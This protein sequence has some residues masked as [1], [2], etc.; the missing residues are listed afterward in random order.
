MLLGFSMQAVAGCIDDSGAGHT[1]NSYGVITL[2]SGTMCIEGWTKQN[3][4][5]DFYKLTLQSDGKLT[6]TSHAYDHNHKL[7]IGSSKDGG[8]YYNVGG[9]KKHMTKFDVSEG[10]TI[11]II[12]ASSNGT[13]YRLDIAFDADTTGTGSSGKTLTLTGTLR[14]FNQDHPDFERH[15]SWENGYYVSKNGFLNI[16]NFNDGLKDGLEKGNVLDTLGADGKPVV[17]PDSTNNFKPIRLQDWFHDVEGVNMSMPYSIELTEIGDGIYQFSSDA[18]FPADGKLLGNEVYHGRSDSEYNHNFHMTYELHTKF[19]YREG[20]N[21]VFNFVGDDDVWVF[22][23]NKLV[24]DLGGL[25]NPQTESVNLDDIKNDLNLIDGHT[26][27]LD[28]FWAERHTTGSNFT[29]TTSIA[30]EERKPIQV[31]VVEDFASN[32]YQQKNKIKI[33]DSFTLD[34]VLLNNNNEPTNYHPSQSSNPIPMSVLFYTKKVGS[35][36]DVKRLDGVVARFQGGKEYATS[37]EISPD[38]IDSGEY[39]VNV[40]YLNFYDTSKVNLQQCSQSSLNSTL[41]GLP[42]CVNGEKN[43]RAMFGDAAAEKC[44]SKGN[45]GSQADLPCSSGH[46]SNDV[47]EPYNHEYGCYE[48]T[49]DALWDNKYWQSTATL[50]KEENTKPF[51]CSQDAYLFSG[52]AHSRS[53]HTIDLG[54]GDYKLEKDGIDSQINATGYN[55]KDNMIWGYDINTYKVIKIDADYNIV[56]YKVEGLPDGKYYAGDVSLDG[57]LYLKKHNDNTLYRV[58]LNS[59]TPVYKDKITLSR[60]FLSAIT[61]QTWNFGDFAFNPVDGKLYSINEI[62]EGGSHR[63]YRIDP[64][65]GKMKSFDIGMDEDYERF[66]T[67]VF[68]KSGNLYFYASKGKIY[69]IAIGDGSKNSYSYTLFTQT[70][71]KSGGGDGARCPNAEVTSGPATIVSV[72]DVNQSEGDSGTS[73]MTFTVNFD[74]PVPAST[75]EQE[76][77]FWVTATD[78]VN[79]VEPIGLAGVAEE[80]HEGDERDF[81]FSAFNIM[82]V[83]DP[84]QYRS[85][86]EVHYLKAGKTSYDINVSIIGDLYVEPDEEFYLDLYDFHTVQVGSA[87][88]KIDV[89]GDVGVRAIGTIIDD[90]IAMECSSDSILFKENPSNVYNLNLFNGEITQEA[91]NPFST[92]I[93][94]IGFNSKDGAYWGYATRNLM[95]TSVRDLMKVVKKDG[96]WYSQRIHIDKLPADEYNVGD[97][98]DDGK[99]FLKNAQKKEVYVVDVTELSETFLK[100][101]D[102]F[103]LKPYNVPFVDW[104][105][106][107]N[108]HKL[109]A[110]NT[111]KRG[112]SNR[113]YRIDPKNGYVEDLGEIGLNSSS[114][115]A[116]GA[117]FFDKNGYFYIAENFSGKIYRIDISDP[118]H[119][120]PKALF[121]TKSTPTS[122]S[123]GARCRYAYISKKPIV[124]F[125]KRVVAQ[126]GDEGIT[127]INFTISG[128][129]PID[130]SSINL[131]YKI[132]KG[133]AGEKDYVTAPQK[134]KVIKASDQTRE[135]I[136][137][138]PIIKGDKITEK[139]ENFFI[140]FSS[141]DLLI[142]NGQNRIE[143]QIV[144]NDYNIF[145]AWDF[146]SSSKKIKTK[147]VAQPFDLHIV[148]I[149]KLGTV[150]NT[151][152]ETET[153][154][155]LVDEQKC[156]IVPFDGNMDGFV[157]FNYT[158]L[159][160]G[161]FRFTSPSAVKKAKVQ[162]YWKNGEQVYTSC[163]SDTFAIRPEKY[164]IEVP[165]IVAGK[166]FNITLKALD[167]NG[168]VVTNYEEDEDVYDINVTEL[169]QGC[170]L[171]N[172]LTIQKQQFKQGVAV[173]QGSYPDI[174]KLKF[175]IKESRNGNKEYAHIDTADS[176]EDRFISSAEIIS[177]TIKPAAIEMTW[178][179]QNGDELNAYTYYNNIDDPGSVEAMSAKLDFQI[180][181]LDFHNQPLQNYTHTCQFAEDVDVKIVYDLESDE[182]RTPL[183]PIGIYSDENN[184][185][186]YDAEDVGQLSFVKGG[187]RVMHYKVDKRFFDAGQANKL[188]LFNFKRDS[189]KPM[190]PTLLK[191]KEVNASLG[192][193]SVHNNEP[194]EVL[195]LYARAHIPDQTFVGDEGNAKVFYEI[196]CKD[197]NRTKYGLETLRESV[198]SINWYI[199]ENLSETYSNFSVPPSLNGLNTSGE[200]IFA[201]HSVF[202]G[203]PSRVSNRALGIKVKKSPTVVRLKYQPKPYLIFN[204]FNPN[205]DSHSFTASFAPKEKS[206]GGKGNVGTTVDMQIAPRNNLDIIDW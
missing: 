37:N 74:K 46:G 189:S 199:L 89:D 72:T 125:Q 36:E 69:K 136:L 130:F 91:T 96:R 35:D 58:D 11:Y 57:I 38:L 43:Y 127:D 117:V 62:E 24:I 6:V 147:I 5:R 16:Y 20:A 59:G 157:D 159:V 41:K 68:D 206:W 50:I 172:G 187:S 54:T 101:V 39:E 95:D 166:D 76:V 179:L 64:E 152:N 169:G 185:T 55:V 47:A 21:Q 203:V 61:G 9:K 83:D 134:F 44:F 113:L 107:P 184:H 161:R 66:H 90:D 98:D 148:K 78:G 201:G 186:R 164:T 173:L 103:T 192:S 49:I 119:V 193:I 165:E 121:L 63:L 190:N 48:C 106:N 7:K 200:S 30:L 174:G 196:Y 34:A 150:V 85:N 88:R 112:E 8:E 4:K 202:D 194:K 167:A 144:D 99:L 204:R 140:E 18:F 65:S 118:K 71:I 109:Y 12:L 154:V 158:G 183:E 178:E 84:S 114:S 87:V 145:N 14:D 86:E 17:N 123:D 171:N 45:H 132:I 153:K 70:E 40:K 29:I 197:C 180:K 205:A 79:A 81:A 100:V 181:A 93:N 143:V 53:A 111:S 120:D 135:Y 128:D 27:K 191:L 28:F 22:I 77:S 160:D 94:G 73:Q 110:V 75:D 60:S 141:D 3:K 195:F 176:M 52:P 32:G 115:H 131:S 155:R 168:Q 188:A 163:S 56:S 162:F 102:K 2:S 26:Y 198:D 133:S 182:T 116:F 15:A 25:H 80:G 10:D 139:T 137:S 42:A 138:L 156:N 104:A 151:G 23:N 175:S 129:R 108:D 13:D 67:F 33:Q 51:T 146:D 82:F 122:N 105:F 97:V 92:V 149:D 31:D 177:D 124:S 142:I 170:R 1:K 19:T 126:E